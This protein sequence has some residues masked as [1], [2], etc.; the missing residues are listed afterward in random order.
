MIENQ[1]VNSVVWVHRDELKANSYN[2]NH[3][4]PPEKRLLKI[5]ILE[6]GWTMP[7]VVRS[8]MEIVDGFHRWLVSK[9][10]DVY[11]LTN[12]FVPV[13][14]LHESKSL[15]DQ[16]MSTIRH[17]RAR[18]IHH[19]VKMSEIVEALA[20]DGLTADEIAGRLQMDE[21]E[22]SRLLDHGNMLKRGS[23]PVFNQGWVPTD[24]P[25]VREVDVQETSEE[26][27]EAA[28]SGV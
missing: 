11:D 4:A 18:G 25:E 27:S 10:R 24:E 13:V 12:G 19:V 1:P 22:V 7:I 20:D 8:D 17:N 6:D 28:P 3:V 5:S 9:D 15:A 21:E 2:P 23:L 14:K 26:E 16:M